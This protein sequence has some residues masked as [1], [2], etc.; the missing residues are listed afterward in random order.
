[1]GV[2]SE[3]EHFRLGGYGGAVHEESHQEPV[4]LGDETGVGLSVRKA[5]LVVRRAPLR[6]RG[7]G[8]LNLQHRS[9]ISFCERT[10]LD[11]GHGRQQVLL[12]SATAGDC[13]T[14]TICWP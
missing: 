14:S 7:R 3:V 13:S 1:M 9:N 12:G 6:G 2:D 11:V 4:D 5:P 8:V 10:D